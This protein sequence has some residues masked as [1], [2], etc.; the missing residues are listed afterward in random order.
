MTL[1]GTDSKTGSNTY[2]IQLSLEKSADDTSNGSESQLMN[3]ENDSFQ[4][5][6]ENLMYQSKYVFLF[7]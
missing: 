1:L 2:L 4:N 3:I 5:I 6:N 7:N